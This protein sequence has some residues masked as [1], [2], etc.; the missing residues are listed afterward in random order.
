MHLLQVVPG[1][2]SGFRRRYDSSRQAFDFDFFAGWSLRAVPFWL[3]TVSESLACSTPLDISKANIPA[4]ELRWCMS[5][6]RGRA[7]NNGSSATQANVS[8][9]FP[10]CS[11]LIGPNV[12]AA[13][14]RC[15]NPQSRRAARVFLL[16]P[17]QNNDV[18]SS[19]PRWAEQTTKPLSAKALDWQTTIIGIRRGLL[20]GPHFLRLPEGFPRV[21]GSFSTQRITWQED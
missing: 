6:L 20:K 12:H 13:S 21:S 16:R 1:M 5:M 18:R 10:D 4:R 14:C 7:P 11:N 9:T 8:T 19:E 15:E 3:A 17:S 2:Y